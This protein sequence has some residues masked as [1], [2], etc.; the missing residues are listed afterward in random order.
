MKT[1]LPKQGKL[2][3]F[4]C[5]VLFNLASVV[6]FLLGTASFTMCMFLFPNP[7]FAWLFANGVGGISHFGANYIMQRQTKDKIA[8]NFIVFNATGMVGFLISSAMFGFAIVYIQDSTAAW[9]LGSAVGTFTH[10]VLNERAMKLN[11]ESLK[12]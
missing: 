7:T 12:H 5:F 9:L 11:I 2:A 8:K 3:V 1:E 4:K 10:F 6:G